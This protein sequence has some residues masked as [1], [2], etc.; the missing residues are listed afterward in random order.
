MIPHGMVVAR[1]PDIPM[2]VIISKQKDGCGERKGGD[3][4]SGYLELRADCLVGYDFTV[5][6]KGWYPSYPNTVLL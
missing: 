4:V 5:T 2:E 3:A 1:T 6:F